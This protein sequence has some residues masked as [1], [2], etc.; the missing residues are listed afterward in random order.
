MKRLLAL[1]ISVVLVF[2]MVACVSEGD[3]PVSASVIE[4]D[5]FGDV[6][7]DLKEIDLEYGDSVNISFSGGYEMKEIPYYPDF[8]GNK[9][10]AVLTDY[11][12][13]ICIAGIGCSFNNLAGIE[14]GEDVRI[15]LEQEGRYKDVENR[16][17][18]KELLEAMYDELPASRKK[19]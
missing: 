1:F 6:M 18:L 9:G 12:D 19:A 2:S 10:A 14:I 11:Y 3:K 4:E 5:Q 15:S 16:D 8:Y 13:T 17:F 7:L